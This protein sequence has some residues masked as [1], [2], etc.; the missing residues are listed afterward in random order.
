MDI[1]SVVLKFVQRC[2]GILFVK[3]EVKTVKKKK[4]DRPTLLIFF[5]RGQ[6]NNFFFLALLQ[7]S[8]SPAQEHSLLL[9]LSL[10]VHQVLGFLLLA[11]ANGLY[12]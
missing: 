3:L 8:V 5:M 6:T 7:L 9:V 12:Q 10:P 1:T 11:V 4:I 2:P